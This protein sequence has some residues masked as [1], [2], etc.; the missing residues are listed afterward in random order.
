V[1]L[2]LEG[3][4]LL[5]SRNLQDLSLSTGPSSRGTHVAWPALWLALQEAGVQLSS[6][7]VA[8]FE[9]AIDE[10]FGYL[11]SYS[12]L[13]KLIIP[14]IQ[15]NQQAAED[16]AGNFFWSEVVVKHKDSL[17]ELALQPV[18][19]GVWCYGPAASRAI[20]QCSSLR[21]LALGLCEINQDWALARVAQ[22]RENNPVGM[23]E[24]DQTWDHTNRCFVCSPAG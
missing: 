10:M 15:M 18:Y 19:E 13:K 11:R 14:R 4:K 1:P 6:L 22:L 7:S 16:A 3:L 5:C 17:T 20:Q 8:G 24:L 12:K 21:E 2:P 23:P 9:G